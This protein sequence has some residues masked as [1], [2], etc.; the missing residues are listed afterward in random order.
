MADMYDDFE[1]ERF[2]VIA[3]LRVANTVWHKEARE[4][5]HTAHL[6]F[7]ICTGNLKNRVEA[8]D[9]NAVVTVINR[10]NIPWLVEHYKSKWP[11]KM[12]VIDESSS[13]KSGTSKR[14]R[15]LKKVMKYVDRCVLL[16]GTPASNG[17]LDLWSQFYLLDMGARLGFTLTMFR[18][19]YFNSDFMGYTYT[20]KSGAMHTIQ[21][22]IQDLVLS[23]DSK[24]Y[25][26][27]PENVPSVLTN[28]L[29]GTLLKQYNKF[30]KDALLSVGKD[31]LTAVSAAVLTNKLLQFSSGAVYD[32]DKKVH[33]FHDLKFDTL[34]EIIEANPEENLL[35][36]YNYKHELARLVERYPDAVVMDKGGEAI[37]A[38]N[39]GEIKMLLV[40]PKSAG[41]GLNLQHGGN[42]LVWF[43]F[44]WSLEEYQQLNKRL[45][46]QGQKN[47]VRTIH[48]AVGEV[49]ER[50][51]RAIARKDITQADLLRSLE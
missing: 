10:E 1:I 31:E 43:S 2:L 6:G 14:F 25:L 26:E 7:S 32:E 50:L 27:L 48:I 9:K 44:T 19:S 47:I 39:K 17:Y 36:A 46:R 49:E 24:D 51:M 34:D 20:L 37:E 13:F 33:H 5:E 35:I 30:E 42:I 16:T 41:H 12:I 8:L 3:P 15:A 45:H 38:W 28:K 18:N 11:F 29:T 22:K 4:W 21:N 40:H 23:M